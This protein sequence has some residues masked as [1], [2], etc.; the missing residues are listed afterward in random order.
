[1]IGAAYEGTRPLLFEVQAL[2]ATTNMNY[3]RRTSIGFDYGRLNMILAVLE[4]RV[5]LRLSDQ[6]VSVNVVGGLHPD[7]T[8]TD[9]SVAM[10]VWSSVKGIVWDKDMMAIGEIGLTGDLRPVQNAEKIVR[11][12]VR[13]GFRQILLPA[14]QADT[15]RDALQGKGTVAD[16]KITGVRRLTDILHR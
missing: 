1:M 16:V 10:A 4:R 13:M 11:E 7:G 14:S 2:A 5:G 6:D 12:A 8:S 3:P 9:L 15:I